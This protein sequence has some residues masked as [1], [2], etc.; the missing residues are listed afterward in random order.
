V[1]P[2]NA[3]Q[4]FVNTHV[5]V[6]PR[7]CPRVSHPR[8]HRRLAPRRARCLCRLPHGIWCPG[9]WYQRPLQSARNSCMVP[10][11]Q[12]QARRTV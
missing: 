10:P 12:H 5:C 4:L 6:G 3:K 1:D 7:T 8:L 9:P 2:T 11:A